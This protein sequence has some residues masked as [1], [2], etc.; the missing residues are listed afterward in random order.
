MPT[1]R[2]TVP[3]TGRDAAERHRVSTPL[4]LLFD[5]TF[6]VAVSQ[7]AAQLAHRVAANDPAAAVPGYLM[8]FFAIWWAWVNFS[9]FA[10]AYDTDD[11]PYR[12]LTLL[13]MAGV[14]V[15]AAGVPSA[16]DLHNFTAITVGYVIMR[17]A[18]IGQWLRAAAGD[19][20]HRRVARRYAAGIG[21]VQV[22][23][24]VRLALPHTV[25]TASFIVLAVAELAMPLW[26][27]RGVGLNWHPHHIA[28]RYGLFTIIVLGECVTAAA[29]AIQ[30]SVVEGGWNTDV[31]LTFA[32]ALV[33]L[34]ACWW[35]YYLKPAGEGLERR[36]DLSFWWGYGHY[37]IFGSLAALGAGLEVAAEATSH[38]IAASDSLVAFAV[39]V[40]V[41]GFLLLVWALH[42]PLA[43]ARPGD[44]PTVLA[45]IAGTLLIAALTIAGL[46]L[47]VA[48]LGMALPAAAIVLAAVLTGRDAEANTAEANTASG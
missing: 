15:L 30:A 10:S 16:F 37:G 27:E 26:A 4:E 12:V 23:W 29:V 18:M 41:S 33:L 36:R 17:V 28:E 7:V 34:F 13:Q 32:G 43:G 9:W 14:L 5:L 11:A 19:A 38:H 6:V 39:A 1:S 45:A 3:M 21:L 44:L 35:I 8:V 42:A 46:A 47:P 24:V 25:G 40:P 22:G 20:G 31:V 48:V 2:F